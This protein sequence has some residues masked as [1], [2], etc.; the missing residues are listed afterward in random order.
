MHHFTHDSIACLVGSRIPIQRI[1]QSFSL[2]HFHILLLCQAYKAHGRQ[3]AHGMLLTLWQYITERVEWPAG[4][5]V[6]ANVNL[7]GFYRVNYE[8]SDWCQITTYLKTNI[9]S[10][11]MVSP[12]SPLCKISREGGRGETVTS[13]RMTAFTSMLWRKEGLLLPP[14]HLSMLH[15]L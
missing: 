8:L 4:G 9:G 1:N 2:V 3:T 6:K 15:M 11:D 13:Y 7:T 12:L 14:W 5:F 10:H